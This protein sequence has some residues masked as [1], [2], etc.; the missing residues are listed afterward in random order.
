MYGSQVSNNVRLSTS[1]A[2]II[3]AYRITGTRRWYSWIR[4]GYLY[5]DCLPH[6]TAAANHK[7][8]PLY[9]VIM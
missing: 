1:V 4:S 9:R 7:R 8:H 3:Y 2:H 5:W 6:P